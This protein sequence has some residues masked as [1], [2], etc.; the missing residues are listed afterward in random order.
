MIYVTSI[1]LVLVL[2]AYV[3]TRTYAKEEWDSLDRKEHP[4]SV[5]YP[6]VILIQRK[7]LKQGSHLP[8]EIL[9]F[10]RKK[11]ACMIFIFLL[12]L[13][14]SFLYELKQITTSPQ[15]IEN[16]IL[17]PKPG[18]GD[19]A[20]EIQ[21]NT[22]FGARQMRLQVKEQV[23]PQ[24]EQRIEMF[25]KAF[26]SLEKL[27]LGKNKS[28]NCIQ[29]DFNLVRSIP[30]TKI[31]VEYS[32]QGIEY[33]DSLGK[34]QFDNL[35]KE[36]TKIIIR[37][38]LL[39]ED[40]WMEQ[41]F[42]ATVLPKKETS[43]HE[44]SEKIKQRLQ[45]LNEQTKEQEYYELPQVIEGQ[46]VD[47]EEKKDRSAAM[48]FI[49]GIIGCFLTPMLLEREKK[50]KEAK[51]AEQMLIDYPEIISKFTLFVNA[52][53]TTRAAW[54][55]IVNDY[56]AREPIATKKKRKPSKR[57]AYE[58]MI[59]TKNE[60]EMA[61]SEELT[62]SNFGKRC[63]LLP[64]LR[65]SSILAQNL[66]KGGQGMIQL[67]EAEASEAFLERKEH[68]KRQGEKASTKLLGPSVGMLLIV[69]LVIMIPAFLS[70]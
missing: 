20:Y 4:L 69:L 31:K 43:I 39:Y 55:R 54:A 8:R 42:E 56:I 27:I 17:R 9:W 58:Q 52:G 64:Y 29:Y 24:G 25:E 60:Q 16:K 35:P 18:D 68:A 7:I 51:E 13:I 32:I 36:G 67:L 15:I 6:M 5:L 61:V 2:V 66:K 28:W 70:F 11:G 38:R 33:I 22:P 37:V 49:F 53:M 19:K 46:Y 34:I 3:M 26:I 59:I 57:I 21:V 40:S 65:F 30:Q 23:V 45:L 10:Q 63:K 14:F 1:C 50:E 48:I 62:Y 12:S 41:S 47:W 44:F